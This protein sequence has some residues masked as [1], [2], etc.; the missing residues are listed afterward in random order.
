MV[1]LYG[2]NGELRPQDLAKCMIDTY[3]AMNKHYIPTGYELSAF[4]KYNHPQLRVFDRT[5]KGVITQEDV[6]DTTTR[7]FLSNQPG[8]GSMR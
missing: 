2:P 7:L 1:S 6:R 5:H 3:R 4:A 8:A